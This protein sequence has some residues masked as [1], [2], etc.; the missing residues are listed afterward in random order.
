ML[1]PAAKSVKILHKWIHL[2]LAKRFV[3]TLK[4]VGKADYQTVL[5]PLSKNLNGYGCDFIIRHLG[6]HGNE[7]VVIGRVP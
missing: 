1:L 7:V 3:W 5:E 2:R 4:F 6:N